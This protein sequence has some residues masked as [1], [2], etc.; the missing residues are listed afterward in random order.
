VPERVEA[1]RSAE[2]WKRLLK[3]VDAE[4]DERHE[5]VIVGGAAIRQPEHGTGG[6]ASGR[7]AA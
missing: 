5:L 4:L 3:L 7:L 6:R 2:F 1:L